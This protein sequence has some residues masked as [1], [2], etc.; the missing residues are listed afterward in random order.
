VPDR[1][2][3]RNMLR[4]RLSTYFCGASLALCG[5][6]LIVWIRSAFAADA[7]APVR[8]ARSFVMVSS[9]RGRAYLSYCRFPK[10]KS[11]LD[12]RY[13]FG[14][15]PTAERAVVQEGDYPPAAWFGCWSGYAIDRSTDAEWRLGRMGEVWCPH[16]VFVVL[17]GVLPVREGW[18]HLVRSRRVR[19][20]LCPACG[21]DL[22]ASRDR[23]PECGA[24]AGERAVS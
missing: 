8:T 21:Y 24:A 23:C 22:R 7:C 1:P 12:L 11:P 14:G 17:F 18:K 20:H 6:M 9:D 16:W 10:P 15:D 3:G 19:K 13:G 2:E 4:Q 5:A